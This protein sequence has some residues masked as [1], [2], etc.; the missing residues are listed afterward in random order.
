MESN[1]DRYWFTESA[2][3]QGGPS[4][5]MSYITTG[6]STET[7]ILSM[8]LMPDFEP[9]ICN[10][11]GVKDGKTMQFQ[12]IKPDKDALLLY[13]A[14]IRWPSQQGVLLSTDNAPKELP[15][16]SRIK[17]IFWIFLGLTIRKKIYGVSTIHSRSYTIF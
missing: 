2:Y 3:R 9:A 7:A 10:N 4:T 15:N 6:I 5:A 16:G 14:Q 13:S 11:N 17:A 12:M 8:N 1:S